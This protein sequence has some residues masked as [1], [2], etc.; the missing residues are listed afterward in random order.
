MNCATCHSF[1]DDHP[2]LPEN[3]R[4]GLY[5]LCQSAWVPRGVQHRDSVRCMAWTER[6]E[7]RLQ[8]QCPGCG[9]TAWRW[10]HDCPGCGYD[11]RP[12]RR[13]AKVKTP[14]GKREHGWLRFRRARWE[15]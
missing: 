13:K 5:G 9:A 3:R 2:D 6:E 8:R 11:L 14:A 12:K 1:H 15:Y 4:N 7:E 10:L